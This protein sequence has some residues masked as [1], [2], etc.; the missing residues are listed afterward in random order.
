MC[1]IS[2]LILRVNRIYLHQA[3]L[4]NH[5]D[6]IPQL[7]RRILGPL[8]LER[9]LV[10]GFVGFIIFLT[11]HPMGI[12]K[13]NVF[14]RL[15]YWSPTMWGH[16]KA[17]SC[18]EGTAANQRRS[19]SEGHRFET[20]YLQRLFTVESPLISTL[21]IVKCVHNINSYMR[22]MVD[23]TFICL[24]LERSDMSSVNKRSIRVVA[25]F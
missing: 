3:R 12:G 5:R 4:E 14:Y 8:H 7:T 16:K 24:T 11:Q 9:N 22:L 25:I 15:S 19:G 10:L 17:K 6:K 20:R 13:M 1:N 18:K 23:C 21:P 2:A